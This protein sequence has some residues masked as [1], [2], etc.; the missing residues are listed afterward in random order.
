MAA[1]LSLSSALELAARTIDYRPLSVAGRRLADDL[2]AH[3]RRLS[4]SPSARR[5]PA[6]LINCLDAAGASSPAAARLLDAF[7]EACVERVRRRMDWSVGF[8]G[9]LAVAA[10][11]VVVAFVLIAM[12]LPLIDLVSGLT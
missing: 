10:V 8:A 6:T 4:D 1:E 5:F 7:A 2:S 11:G 9:P 12:L 3:V